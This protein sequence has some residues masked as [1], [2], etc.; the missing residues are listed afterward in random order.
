MEQQIE[1]RCKCADF[2]KP[3]VFLMGESYTPVCSD[4]VP[5][6]NQGFSS[7]CDT[8]GHVEACHKS[9]A[10]LVVEYLTVIHRLQEMEYA[11]DGGNLDHEDVPADELK[12]WFR[13]VWTGDNGNKSSDISRKHA[14]RGGC[15]EYP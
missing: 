12:N 1:K 6:T 11:V 3:W 15:C 8:C 5:G 4:F 14:H 9:D 10:A 13:Y 2:E 7:L